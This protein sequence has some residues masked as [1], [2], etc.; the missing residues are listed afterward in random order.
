MTG[1]IADRKSEEERTRKRLHDIEGILGLLV[2]EQKRNRRQEADQYKRVDF[3]LRMLTLVVAIAAIVVP[4]TI[5][6]SHLGG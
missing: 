6:L 1:I 4:L 5:T 2:D 3:R